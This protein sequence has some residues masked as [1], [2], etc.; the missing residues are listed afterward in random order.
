[1]NVRIVVL[2]T[3]LALFH[4]LCCTPAGNTHFHDIYHI[5]SPTSYEFHKLGRGLNLDRSVMEG[6][7][8]EARRLSAD[9]LLA[10]VITKWLTLNYPQE[11]YGSPSLS[12]L[13][14]AVYKYDRQLAV[15]IFKQF[16]ATGGESWFT[17]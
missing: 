2:S 15:K 8:Y 4:S 7:L 9:E 11:K 17:C 14:K 5:L 12:L 13:V 16:T 1:M 10:Q 6:I 3:L